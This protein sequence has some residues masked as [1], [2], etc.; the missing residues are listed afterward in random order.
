MECKKI[1]LGIALFAL[2][3]MAGCT[4]TSKPC[5]NKNVA[6]GND[7][8]CVARDGTPISGM[9]Y[10]NAKM[11]QLRT[12]LVVCVA[13]AADGSA[14]GY[15]NMTYFK[16]NNAVVAGGNCNGGESP[17]MTNGLPIPQGGQQDQESV[18]ICIDDIPN[19]CVREQCRVMM[20]GSGAQQ[21]LPVMSAQD[22]QNSVSVGA[23]GAVTAD[24]S[25]TDITT[26]TDDG[27]IN[28]Y[29]SACS[30]MPMNRKTLNLATKAKGKL[31]ANTFR[32]GLGY[33]FAEY[34]E[35]KNYFPLTDRFCGPA[36][37][38]ATKD[39]YTNYVL[40]AGQGSPCVLPPNVA[41]LPDLYRCP[42]SSDLYATL[43][44]CKIN[45]GDTCVSGT[46][47]WRRSICTRTS[48][49]YD[50]ADE[51]L[52][53]CHVPS[54]PVTLY[55][56]ATRTQNAYPY[57]NPFLNAS[58]DYK[59]DANT[60]IDREYYKNYYEAT[61][62]FRQQNATGYN[63]LVDGNVVHHGGMEME[64]LSSSQCMSGY[65]N[66]NEHNRKVCLNKTSEDGIN[67]EC[68]V[69]QGVTKCPVGDG[70][71]YWEFDIRYKCEF[72]KGGADYIGNNA[73]F[74]TVNFYSER[75]P[76][77]GGEQWRG[78]IEG[79]DPEHLGPQN[80]Y[81]TP[82]RDSANVNGP[83]VACPGQD[84]FLSN[85]DGFPVNGNCDPD[86]GY[87]CGLYGEVGSTTV[88]GVVVHIK[89]SIVNAQ[90]KD[91]EAL[92][93]AQGGRYG[94]GK[95]T[96][97]VSYSNQQDVSPSIE[98]LRRQLPFLD[99]CAVP[100]GDIAAYPAYSNKHAIVAEV[101]ISVNN[102]GEGEHLG[103]GDCEFMNG[104]GMIIGQYGWCEPCT[105]STVARQAVSASMHNGADIN[106]QQFSPGIS[107]INEHLDKYLKAS[108]MPVLDVREAAM[109]NNFAS[110][111]VYE[112]STH[113]YA[114][115]QEQAEALDGKYRI[116]IT[117]ILKTDGV[118]RGAV[119]LVIANVEDFTDEPSGFWA[120]GGTYGINCGGDGQPACV[121]IF[122]GR[123][124]AMGAGDAR[125][126]ILKEVQ[127]S[128]GAYYEF[129]NNS[130][131]E[132]DGRG[133]T[134]R[135]YYLLKANLMKEACP[136]CLIAVAAKNRNFYEENL[137][138]DDALS[139]NPNNPFGKLFGST[140]P[141]L[142]ADWQNDP[143]TDAI[144]LIAAD[145]SIDAVA[146]K[147]PVSEVNEQVNYSGKLIK[148]Y[149]KP[150][151]DWGLEVITAYVGEDGSHNSNHTDYTNT[152]NA[153]FDNQ[154]DLTSAGT[155]GVMYSP[156][157][158]GWA[159]LAKEDNIVGKRG[160]GSWTMLGGNN[161]YYAGDFCAVYSA[162][163]KILGLKESTVYEKIYAVDACECVPCT[164]DEIEAG[165]CG[166]LGLGVRE[167]GMDAQLRCSL[168]AGVAQADAA[169]YKAPQSCITNSCAQCENGAGTA[170][171]SRIEEGEVSKMG[172]KPISQLND[173]YKDIIAALAPQY[174]C[175][176]NDSD[177]NYTYIQYTG[178]I[179]KNE[180]VLYH[181]SGSLTFDCGK[182]PD[183]SSG[184]CGIDIKAE[185]AQV[186]CSYQR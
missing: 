74:C 5:C 96:T 165:Q 156:W 118:D 38:D 9:P 103:I 84:G 112:A 39:R 180:Q 85:L 45:C 166:N 160:D 106:G 42:G 99:R 14:E 168:P 170:I 102:R 22:V 59:L 34:E 30:V 63:E 136:D 128:N 174:K 15:C 12:E 95:Y 108:V 37:P 20:C 149:H 147:D 69:D 98:I 46:P 6:L 183:L 114:T 57:P 40:P 89:K 126:W 55:C 104:I 181:K 66:S 90:Q 65:C 111:L 71:K 184:T 44:A 186:V 182:T 1:A 145:W 151:L 97:Y 177:G 73:P 52:L 31:W 13:P 87:S 146:A 115:G 125:Q 3:I 56:P 79:M 26:Y 178:Q 116:P 142:F 91:S 134:K 58:G 53:N 23:G 50:T 21:T 154:R 109:Q 41:P 29:K 120:M 93:P 16:C 105:Y 100:D 141:A 163:R 157:K 113:N 48:R 176:I 8:A 172:N 135:E 138:A 123:Q 64:C 127:N 81:P 68:I 173:A 150:I 80:G 25:K 61:Q 92:V 117:E 131:L 158:A 119:T 144:D 148:R 121:G 10:G 139:A 75:A 169:N 78:I 77:G 67:C 18:P 129:T 4:S 167:N 110:S 171:C 143:Q 130:R 164:Q 17:V 33:T 76:G 152:M 7:P 162:S 54:E 24:L 43:D 88:D 60:E 101:D 155:M 94:L 47:G 62:Y 82:C 107:Y 72:S 83:V 137:E 2:L 133:L 27:P 11:P 51:C 159:A 124:E 175:C 70:A 122:G 28:L 19:P 161:A 35:S 86:A 36:N 32:F 49:A 153:I 179:Q 132:E 185:S 140:R